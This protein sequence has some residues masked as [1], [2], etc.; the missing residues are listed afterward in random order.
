MRCVLLG[1]QND[2]Q[3]EDKLKTK[4]NPGRIKKVFSR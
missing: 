4:I 2:G 3:L 1:K